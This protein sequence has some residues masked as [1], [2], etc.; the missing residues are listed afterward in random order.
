MSTPLLGNESNE[1]KNSS[2][3]S[4]SGKLL[5][6]TNLDQFVRWMMLIETW[7]AYHEVS[8]WTIHT[9]TFYTIKY[10]N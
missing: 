5:V 2:P 1:E 10:S 9:Q 7:Y 6:T 4:Q 8:I 3:Y